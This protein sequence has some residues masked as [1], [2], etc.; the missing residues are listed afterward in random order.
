MIVDYIGSLDNRHKLSE[1]T[2]STGTKLLL[3]PEE[4]D[5]FVFNI[6]MLDV[7][8]DFVDNEEYADVDTYNEPLDIKEP[9]E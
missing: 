8:E 3:S 7:L 6:Q 5:E 9:N 2:L 1:Y 4:V